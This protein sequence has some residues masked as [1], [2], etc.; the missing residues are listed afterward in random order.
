[1]EKFY[2]VTNEKFLKEIDDYRKHEEERRTLANNFFE[3]KGIAGK[4]RI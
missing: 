2:I 3:N 1:M 4:E